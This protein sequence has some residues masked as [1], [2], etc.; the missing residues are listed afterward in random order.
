MP[1][2][3]PRHVCQLCGKV[4]HLAS[5]CYSRFDQSFQNEAI[6]QPQALYS[7]PNVIS[8]EDWYPDTGAT[9]HITN[10][11][12]K[13]NLTSEEYSGSDQIRVGNGSGLSISHMGSA[14]ISNSRRQF[15]LKQLFLVPN[16]CKNLL[17]VSQFATDNDVFFEFHS[18]YFV[19]KDR[20]TRITLYQGPLKNGLYQFQPFSTSSS[21]SHALVGERTSS[22]HW[23]RCLGHPVFR[24]VQRILSTFKLPV[25][26]NK[27][28]G[29]CSICPIAKGHQL[30]FHDSSSSICNPL[31]LI[32]SDVWGPS[33]VLS[34]N[35]NRYY[36]SFIDAY[37][38]F[39][40]LF[41]IQNK[42]DVKSVFISFQTMVECLFSRKIKSVQSDWGGEYRSLHTYF[43]Y[44]GI[45]HRLSCPHTHQQQGCVDRKHRHIIDTT[46][47]LLADNGVPKQFWDEACLTSCYLINR[48]PTPLLK[49]ISPFEK[50]FSQAPNYHHL[51]IFGCECF[52]NLRPYNSHK[53]EFRSK[54]CVF[55]GYSTNHKG[56]RCYHI[57]S[58]RMYIS[59]DVTF[60]ESI[61]PFHSNSNSKSSSSISQSTPTIIE[62]PTY[63][64]SPPLVQQLQSG[65][66][67]KS[68]QPVNSLTS[69]N[70]TDAIQSPPSSQPTPSVQPLV[71]SQLQPVSITNS[72]NTLP[73]SHIPSSPQ[74][75]S[76]PNT[77]SSTTPTVNHELHENI[78][79]PQLSS[80]PRLHHMVTRA[81]NH[82]SKP[83]TYTDGT[84][85][86][87]LARALLSTTEASLIEPMCFTKAVQIPEWCNAMQTEF[88][89]LLSNQTWTLVPSN[90]ANNVIGCKWVFKVKRKA[91]GSL[92]RYK[93]RL[94]AK[95][96]Y[97]Q[98]GVDFRET[99]S[100]VVKPT[101]IQ[102]IL[103]VAYSAG[104]KMQ[105]IDIQNAFL[106]GLLTEE[107]FMSQPPGFTHPSYPQHICK[108]N[109]AIYG[110]K[111][112]PQ[113][114]FSRLTNKLLSIGFTASKADSSL[115]LFKSKIVTIFILIYV[116]DIIITASQPS[117]ISELLQ[118][119]RMDFAVKDL[120]NLHYFLG[121][122]VQHTNSGLF[123]S[124]RRYIEDLLRRT[125]MHEAK[126]ISSP[127]SSS[128]GISAFIGDPMEDPSLYR[129]TVGSLQYLSLTRP[130]LAF[131]VNRVCQFMHHPTKLH[132]QAVKRILRYLKHTITHDLL[133]KRTLSSTIQAYSDADW[134][135]CPDDRKST[136]A[137]CVFIGSILSHGAHRNNPL[138]PGQ[139]RKR[140][141]K[142]LPTL[143]LRNYGLKFSY[144]ILE[145]Q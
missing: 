59:R 127:M 92:E 143:Q 50:L 141:T 138:F 103:S 5:R 54:S 102:T 111:Q 32:Y 41:P 47:A 52:P 33:P 93:A 24:V 83:K 69:Y 117:A 94:V 15:I 135:G 36:I 37:S 43:K 72:S 130:D 29:P 112:A 57:E 100:P 96:F 46:L 109:K 62:S 122:E 86:Y 97:Q 137:Y 11:L 1:S 74:T 95:G 35:G 20:L 98:A 31:D 14:T 9:H 26:F 51:K 108:L 116:D 18:S 106:H 85:R 144:V 120:G 133:L 121:V 125:N 16:I 66:H 60:H 10:D 61:F 53:F 119:L 115:F 128:I 131:S 44:I 81:Q 104:W 17:S 110:L 4:G 75:P 140:S 3:S 123:L 118:L 142:W 27:N 77:H 28:C 101:T 126:P 73:P 21:I 65:S 124:Q 105:Q 82:I 88:N 38:R 48:L 89:A 67:I 139:A 25:K 84:I 22:D 145:S 40:W 136:G 19:I 8:N 42:S 39:M 7:S 34:I 49:I 71:S 129:S 114:W 64:Q 91:D 134:A 90:T 70:P 56:Y 113:A 107:V 76:S 80:P 23:Y 45:I 99:F 79:T 2:G 63:F 12:T 13:L 78:D 87:P 6:T 68:I 55:L 132:W 58:G 30:P